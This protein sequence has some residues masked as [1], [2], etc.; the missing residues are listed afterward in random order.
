MREQSRTA[1]LVQEV[2]VPCPSA[3]TNLPLGQAWHCCE[4]T[5]SW[6]RPLPHCGHS[7]APSTLDARPLSK[8]RDT[9]TTTVSSESRQRVAK[10][11]DRQTQHGNR[12]RQ[13]RKRHAQ[14]RHEE[15]C[16]RLALLAEVEPLE[17]AV[18]AARAQ[19]A[20]ERPGHVR[21][22]AVRAEQARGPAGRVDVL[23]QRAERAQAQAVLIASSAC[24]KPEQGGT[25]TVS[26]SRN[27]N[28]TCKPKPTRT[29]HTARR[30]RFAFGAEGHSR[31]GLVLARAALHAEGRLGLVLERAVTTCIQ[32]ARPEARSANK[33]GWSANEPRLKT[34]QQT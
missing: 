34:G 28:E 2:Q 26:A 8:F 14:K 6:K 33:D 9:N 23:P 21:E 5:R 17:R 4:P 16:L 24:S 7:T 30:T 31:E 27:M 3:A 1:R 18:P 15:L 10:Q 11:A 13:T 29:S 19:L 32:R 22:G 25:Q 20:A 12:A